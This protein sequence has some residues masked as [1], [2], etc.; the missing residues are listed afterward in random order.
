MLLR[1]LMRLSRLTT[2]TLSL[3]ILMRYGNTNIVKAMLDLKS[4]IAE[5][6]VTCKEFWYPELFKCFKKC[7]SNG[8]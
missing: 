8:G 6:R 2:S 4:P 3:V 1:Y 5:S 7:F